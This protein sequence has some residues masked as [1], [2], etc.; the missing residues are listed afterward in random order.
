M[1]SLLKWKAEGK[2]GD[3]VWVTPKIPFLIPILLG[4]LVAIIY[5]D[6]LTQVVSFFLFR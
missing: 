3:K 6:I 4:F 2:V 1:I 5:G